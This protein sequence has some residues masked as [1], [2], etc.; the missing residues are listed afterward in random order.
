MISDFK[1]GIA[2]GRRQNY[3]FI[4]LHHDTKGEVIAVLK[5]DGSYKF[6]PWR[7][8]ITSAMAK[9]IR[10]VPVKLL[11]TS[12]GYQKHGSMRWKD[13]PDGKH[14]QGCLVNE[15]CYCVLQGKVRLI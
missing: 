15:G 4:A 9:E 7:G 5:R 13:V 1:P 10:G 8:F 2:L 12:V 3:K 11:V 6:A 14:V